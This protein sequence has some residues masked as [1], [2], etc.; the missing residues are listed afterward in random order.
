LA[1]LRISLHDAN[2]STHGE[3]RKKGGT[4]HGTQR[5]HQL[6]GSNGSKLKGVT[7]KKLLGGSLLMWAVL[8]SVPQVGF[9]KD[10]T[11]HEPHWRR[12][13]QVRGEKI[14]DIPE[15]DG[16]VAGQAL[17]LLIGGSVLVLDRARR[18]RA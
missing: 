13:H 6:S 16:A 10:N 5:A 4:G 18:K 15:L 11:I 9:A 12:W 14:A 8:A 7:M 1:R 3:Y 2:R 17:A